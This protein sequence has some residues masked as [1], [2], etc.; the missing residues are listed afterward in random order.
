MV[1]LAGAAVVA[2]LT[3]APSAGGKTRLFQSLGCAP[4]PALTAALLLDTADAT[5]A[6]GVH[7]VVFTEPA[8]A[9]HEV[10]MLLPEVEVLPQS[11]GTLG[12]R[13]AAA[14]RALFARGAFA[15][16][17]IG[18]DLPDLPEEVVA[19]A[20]D[21][22]RRD[23]ATVVLGP[24]RDGGYYLIGATAVPPLFDGIDWGGTSVFAQ[25]VD[26]AFRRGLRVRR[27]PVVGD[28][29][30]MDELRRVTARRTRE[31]WTKHSC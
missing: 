24:A 20:F 29:D 23:P 28:V 9:C 15:V 27:L 7:R 25:T 13:M 19:A 21:W 6:P 14:F 4:D 11:P 10:H 22:L 3:R 31:W 12:D 18:S 1:D 17:L 26:L 8:D 2:I 5:A 30:T 16:V